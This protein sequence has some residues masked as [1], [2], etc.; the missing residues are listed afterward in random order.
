MDPLPNFTPR[1]QQAIKLAKTI[2]VEH[3]LATV[4]VLHLL[5]GVLKVQGNLLFSLEVNQ[6]FNLNLLENFSYSFFGSKRKPVS[7]QA[8][9]IYSKTFKNCL[10]SAAGL[11]KEYGHDYVGAEHIFITLLDNK[12]VKSFFASLKISCSD[13]SF[14]VKSVL[15]GDTLEKDEQLKNSL[16]KLSSLKSSPKIKPNKKLDENSDSYLSQYSVCFT[17][18]A[19]EEKLDLVV[20][21]EKEISELIEVLCRRSKNNPIVLGEAG[22]GKTALIEGL[23]QK[24]ISQDVPDNLLGSEVFSLNLNSIIAGTKYRGEFEQRFKDILNEISLRDK[25]II[26]I[27]EI[28]TLVGA[29]SAEGGIDAANLLKPALSRNYFNCIGATTFEEFKKH[30]E[31]DKALSRRFQKIVVEEPS[32]KECVLILEKLAKDYENFHQV[33]YR[34][35]ALRKAVEL[36]SMYINDRYLPDKAIDIIDEAAA[37]VKVKNLH[38]PKELQNIESSLDS[39][40]DE[41]ASVKNKDQKKVIGE[42]IDNLFEKYQLILDDWQKSLKKRVLYVSESDVLEVISLKTSIPVSIL[43]SSSDEKYLKLESNLKK[44]II[45]QDEAISSICDSIIRS[46]CG[47]NNPQK[48]TGVF[49]LL[50]QTGTGKTLMSKKISENLF[51]G[52]DK[53]IRLDMGEFS[54][55]SSV[56]KITGSSPGYVGYSQGSLLVDSVRKNPYSVVLFD[57]IEKAHPEVLKSLLSIL[58]EGYLFDSHG[59]KADFR[60]CLII[61]TS[62]LGS[63]LMSKTQHGVGFMA[64]ET[65]KILYQDKLKESVVK[66]FSPEF[67]NRIDEVISFKSFSNKSLFKMIKIYLLDL[68]KKLSRKKIKISL[69]S[70]LIDYFIS[71]LVDLNLGARPIERLYK[72]HIESLIAKDLLRGK[73]SPSSKIKFFYIDDLVSY[74]IL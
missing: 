5:Y 65:N 29:G 71:K 34:K 47:L 31:V 33:K 68:N 67:V 16:E 1:V 9:L 39:L 25:I 46:S 53:L 59:R 11:A 52:L 42:C 56:S 51:G 44:S 69:D 22:V 3:N 62:N 13:L 38:R 64:P 4:E 24:I 2:C 26:F 74:N 21:R 58:D 49:L 73:I 50:G 15:E 28:H 6:N 57:E 14:S 55:S 70:T 8:H 19:R 36:S 7:P 30:I 17:Q 23:S 35:G 37:K 72:H 45:G 32:D 48:P 10:R 40:I 27:D 12:D 41:E 18:L 66:H 54:E 61:L 43:S 63:E 60:N 20:N